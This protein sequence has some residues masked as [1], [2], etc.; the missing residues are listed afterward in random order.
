MFMLKSQH[1]LWFKFV[2]LKWALEL[3]NETEKNSCKMSL[4]L[5]DSVHFQ[6]NENKQKIYVYYS[7]FIKIKYNI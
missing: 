6:N 7:K 2:I 4:Q 1:H 3:F 5:I